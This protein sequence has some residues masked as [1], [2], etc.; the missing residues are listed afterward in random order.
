MDAATA[1]PSAGPS[2]AAAARYAILVRFELKPGA[3][4]RFMELIAANAAA[5]VRD[6][7]GCFRFDV[8]TVGESSGQVTLYEIYSDRAAFDEHCRTPHFLS[9]RDAVAGL[10]DGQRVDEFQVAENAKPV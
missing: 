3:F 7:P 8:L 6:E 1:S 2:R 4:A 10:V 9:F 5:S